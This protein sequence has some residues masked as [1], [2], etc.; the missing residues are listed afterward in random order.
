MSGD[1]PVEPAFQRPPSAEP[2]YQKPP[3]E[4]ALQPPPVREPVRVEAERA[5]IQHNV[6]PV[7]EISGSTANPK[8]G[9]WRR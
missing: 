8:K 9:W 4:L 3:A 1:S 2:T 5:P 7:Q 6:Q